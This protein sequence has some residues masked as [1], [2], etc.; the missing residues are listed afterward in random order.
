MS[1]AQVLTA[2]LWSPYLSQEVLVLL[3][4]FGKILPLPTRQLYGGVTEELFLRWGLLTFL[5]WLFWRILRKGIG[6]PGPIVF[7]TA[8]I[9]S[10]LVFAAG[11]LPLA[12]FLVSEPTLAL[13]GF[14]IVSNSLFGI[15]AGVL[16]WKKGLES[17]ILAHAIAHLVMLTASHFQAYF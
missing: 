12:F 13:I 16:Y 8:I 15:T 9:I 11:H 2:Y 1:S 17:A 7:I 3:G 4:K 6:T 10:S 14:V 5:V